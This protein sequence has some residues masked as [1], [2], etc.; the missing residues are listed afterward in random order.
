MRRVYTLEGIIIKRNNF[1]EADRFLTFFT[2]YKGKV[3]LLAKGIRKIQ[4]RKAPHLEVFNVVR[5]VAAIGKSVDIITEA[6]IVSTF[7]KLRSNLF[8]LTHAYRAIE[9]IERL[10]PEAESYPSIYHLLLVTIKQLHKLDSDDAEFIIDE[11]SRELLSTLG[12]LP[13]DQKLNGESLS[14]FLSGVMEK[15]LSSDRLLTR[16]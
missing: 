1:G 6:Q 2:R 14:L 9:Q 3:R 15:N 16:I 8:L 11:F 7:P 5:V 13:R 10:C 12:Y 4:S